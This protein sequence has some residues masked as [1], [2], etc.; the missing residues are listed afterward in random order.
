MTRT[1]R[2]VEQHVQITRLAQEL[3]RH[4]VQQTLA[5]DA[6]AARQVLS[7]LSGKLSVHL[8]AEDRLLYPEVLHSPDPATRAVGQ[9]FLEAMGPISQA[10]RRYSIRWGTQD[11]IRSNPEAFV[12]ETKAML[13]DIEGRIRREE[14]ELYPLVE[15]LRSEA[16][17]PAAVRTGR[18]TD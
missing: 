5:V 18:A 3:R 13:T 11:A 15:Q 6:S 4:L 17:A 12:S 7:L 8:A 2:Y 14:A 10:F 1:A 9:R 16:A